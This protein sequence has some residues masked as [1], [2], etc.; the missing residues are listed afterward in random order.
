[1]T[2]QLP[3]HLAN[4][5][6]RDLAETGL[7]GLSRNVP[8]VSIEGTAFTLVDENGVQRPIPK[9]YLD[10]VIIDVTDVVSRVFWGTE[11]M[12]YG[13]PQKAYA[14]KGQGYTPPICFSDNGIGASS[15]AQEPQ[16]QNCKGCQWNDWNSSISRMTGKGIPACGSTKKVALFVPGVA[17]PFLL[18]IPV[19]SHENFKHYL[20][21]FRGQAFKLDEIWTRI[22]FVHGVQGV[23]QFE[24]TSQYEKDW[25]W[26]DDAS[27]QAIDTILTRKMTD[28]LVGRGDIPWTGAG[29]QAALTVQAPMDTPQPLP[30]PPAPAV[31]PVTFAPPPADNA[32]RKRGRPPKQDGTPV[33]PNV[34]V[35]APPPPQAPFGLQE[36]QAPSSDMQNALNAAFGLP[37]GR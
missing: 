9:P 30:P 16:A 4:R 3:A 12:A 14:G 28:P 25:T 20:S 17:F 34:A 10:C 5:A 8:Y 7:T 13:A 19:M 6:R 23:L 18:R 37:T 32:P 1:M 24:P 35:T 33:T 36:G 22:S 15:Q 21:A 29:V 11:G 2:V 31:P 26:V 27:V